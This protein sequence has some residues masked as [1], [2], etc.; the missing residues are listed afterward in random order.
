MSRSKQNR[1][2]RIFSSEFLP[3]VPHVNQAMTTNRKADGGLVASVPVR[4]PRYL[5]PPL[6]WIMPFSS[7]RRIELDSLGASV[8]DM[9]DG[10]RSVEAII[11]E[12]ASDHKLSF[13]EAQLAVTQFVRQLVKRGIVA[14]VGM[15]HAS[16]S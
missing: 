1:Q 8:L 9:C 12:F 11:E 10:R 6:S 2:R 5:V 3:A 15:E 14:M 7:H 13:R 16:E 4:R